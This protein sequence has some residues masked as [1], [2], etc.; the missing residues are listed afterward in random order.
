MKDCE[1]QAAAAG[2]STSGVHNLGS[3]GFDKR[4]MG[5][6]NLHKHLALDT[7]Y[8]EMIDSNEEL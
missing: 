3:K 4:V 5:S 8:E 1:L 2:P 6:N 7:N